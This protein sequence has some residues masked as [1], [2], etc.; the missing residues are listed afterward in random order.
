MVTLV[1]P[2]FNN[3]GYTRACLESLA[4]CARGA[5]FRVV[6]VDNGSSDETVG[7][8][9][10]LGQTLFPGRFECRR[11]EQNLGFARGCNQGASGAATP[12]LL[13]LNNDTT[14]TPGWLETLL[15]GLERGAN[16]AAASPLLLYPGL[17]RV[18][19]AAICFDGE[20]RAAHLF[21]FF[22]KAHPALKTIQHIQALSG[23]A[24]LIRREVFETLGGFHE[25]Y[26]NGS[27]DLDLSCLLRRA[28]CGLAFVPQSVVHHAT[29]MTP[30]RF[31]HIAHN[32]AVF[33]A[34]AKGCFAPDLHRH[35]ARAGFGLRLTAWLEPCL[36]AEAAQLPSPADFG[37]D[38]A[39]LIAALDRQPLWAAGY[40]RLCALLAREPSCAPALAWAEVWSGLCPS[41]E[42]FAA[43]L[44]LAERAADPAA[45]QRW[46]KRLAQ[47]RQTLAA[48]PALRARAELNRAWAQQ[49]G[50]KAWAALYADWLAAGPAEAQPPA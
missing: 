48:S 17:E 30:G 15:Q 6:V 50:H 35:A 4:A 49:A 20:L 3:W 7:G 39:A 23:A 43:A 38:T 14:L 25:A 41:L 45:A 46:R 26:V 10:A 27:E 22:P 33:N 12:F 29:S 36:A 11:F 42:A 34:R 5:A 18:Q 31:D 16:V 9:A 28:G 8:C 32:T 44:D 1:I 21:Q 19:H 37:D 2:A 13:F 40:A 24:L 47:V